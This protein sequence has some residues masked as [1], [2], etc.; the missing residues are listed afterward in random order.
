MGDFL[1][2]KSM[3][4]LV[5]IPRNLRIKLQLLLI[6][7]IQ[8]FYA[9]TVNCQ[10]P[11]ACGVLPANQATSSNPDSIVYDRFG[12]SYDVY[13]AWTSALTLPCNNS[14]YYHLESTLAITP[15][16]EDAFA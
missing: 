3:S 5:K 4:S 13:P 15:A 2:S 9:A 1:L 6:C 8:I 14:G 12:N 7:I 16:M 11:I 10:S